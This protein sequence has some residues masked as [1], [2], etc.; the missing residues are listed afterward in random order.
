ANRLHSV[1]LSCVRTAADARTTSAIATSQAVQRAVEDY[2]WRLPTSTSSG[3]HSAVAAQRFAEDFPQNMP[4]L[5]AESQRPANPVEGENS[6]VHDDLKAIV[7]FFVQQMQ[8]GLSMDEVAQW[9]SDQ[10]PEYSRDLDIVMPIVREML[11][12]VTSTKFRSPRLLLIDNQGTHR[13]L[14]ME[15]FFFDSDAFHRLYNCSFRSQEEWSAYG[16]SNLPLGIVYLVV[17]ITYEVLYIPFL[18]VMASPNFFRLSCYKIMFYLGVVDIITIVDNSLLSGYF[19]LT[20]A[21]YC[22]HPTVMYVS[23][24]CAVGLWCCACMTCMILAINRCL[25]L[26]RPSWMK[27][28]FAGQRTYLWLLMPTVYGL[29]FAW[30]TPPLIFTSIY[31][32][33]FFDPFVGTRA[34]DSHEQEKYALIN[35]GLL[36]TGRKVTGNLYAWL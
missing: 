12:S 11:D 25:D 23:G 21:I 36:T 1:L 34:D 24:S 9:I 28:L 32:A 19:S 27:H 14:T 16:K 8:Q 18:F 31:D 26:L 2:C 17:G 6:D 3:V 4:A 5:S 29:Y 20:G 35:S 10:T 22:T 33:N 15:R 7:D 30:F 13:L